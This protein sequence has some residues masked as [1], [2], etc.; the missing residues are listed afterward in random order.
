ML[1][2]ALAVAKPGLVAAVLVA[3]TMPLIRSVER[4]PGNAGVARVMRWGL[5][6]K[7]VAVPVYLQ[8]VATFYD[9]VA[10]YNRYHGIGSRVAPSLRAG[11]L[12][13]EVGEVVGEGFVGIVT[14]VFYAL[15][16]VS[17][18]AAFVFFSWLAFL[19]MFFFFRAFETALPGADRPRYAKLLFFFPTMVFWSS[20]LGKDAIMVFALG[21]GSFGAARL[22]RQERGGAAVL[23]AGAVV[24]LLVR[25]HMSLLLLCAV[26]LAIAVRRSAPSAAV[27]GVKLVVLAALGLGTLAVAGK[28]A[29]FVGVDSLNPSSVSEVLDETEENTLA[30][31]QGEGTGD[32]FGSSVERSGSRGPLQFPRHAVT[33]LFRPFFFEA[34]NGPAMVASAEGTVMLAL[35]VLARRRLVA[36]PR[37]LRRHPYL[38]LSLAYVIVAIYL[39]S[40]F[41]NLGLL[42]RQRVQL[43]PALLVLLCPP[44]AS[45][46]P[47]PSPAVPG[48]SRRQ[49]WTVPQP[50]PVRWLPLT[51]PGQP[52]GPAAP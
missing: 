11:D 14:G 17:R 7:M 37:L 47:S 1:N 15:L 42:A 25:P 20:A 38:L 45:A 32:R 10:D 31:N 8:V 39:F 19:G 40:S 6:L 34:R 49:L 18:P 33:V 21:V 24:A 48:P 52:R 5:A 22:L 26:G 36:L 30:H 23:G 4:R 27:P 44:S 9:G 12:S 2:N 51:S 46:S 13:L 43:L 50:E 35:V 28:V 3:L 16:G 29:E 41:R